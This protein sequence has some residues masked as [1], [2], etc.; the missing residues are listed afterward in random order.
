MKRQKTLRHALVYWRR[1]FKAHG[2]SIPFAYWIWCRTKK[3]NPL[4][5][6][7]EEFIKHLTD[8]PSK[9]R[10]AM[11]DMYFCD[12]V[13][14]WCIRS[15]AFHV[16]VRYGSLSVYE[17]M[18][19]PSIPLSPL[20]FIEKTITNM[21][22]AKTLYRGMTP[23]GRQVWAEMSPDVLGERE[24]KLLAYMEIVL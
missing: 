15:K 3:I 21:V 1:A 24:K 13:E 4:D 10:R 8:H 12:N 17:G 9:G 20:L 16:N 23:R 6:H 19:D 18:F 22:K 11:F 5:N 14:T 2:L 7:G